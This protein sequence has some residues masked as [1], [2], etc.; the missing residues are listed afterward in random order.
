MGG[1][2]RSAKDDR[3]NC[4]SVS[5]MCVW[6]FAVVIPTAFRFTASKPA[7]QA[8]LIRALHPLRRQAQYRRSNRASARFSSVNALDANGQSG[9]ASGT[10]IT[11]GAGL[12]ANHI[13]KPAHPDFT[14]QTN[15]RIRRNKQDSN[16]SNTTGG[17]PPSP[18][19]VQGR[20]GTRPQQRRQAQRV[21]WRWEAISPTIR[22]GVQSPGSPKIPSRLAGRRCKSKRD[23]PAT[24]CSAGLT[25]I[26]Q[27]A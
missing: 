25:V 14:S 7:R 22:G 20:V 8:G 11:R 3:R 1:A 26:S 15:E 5:G 19:V 6:L 4:Q 9:A 13:P 23:A 17:F 16:G 27:A 18:S 21:F 10:A 24:G 12:R 2:T